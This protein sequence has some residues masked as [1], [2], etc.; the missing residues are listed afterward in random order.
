[1]SDVLSVNRSNQPRTGRLQGDAHRHVDDPT[2][3]AD[4]HQLAGMGGDDAVEGGG[5]TGVQ[6]GDRLAT[7]ID[8]PVGVLQR[9]VRGEAGDQVVVRH[10]VALLARVE[11]G[12]ALVD[13]DLGADHGSDELGRLDRP[14]DVAGI[15]HGAG[16]L[17]RAIE[18]L[19]EQL[20][21]RPTGV[22][23]PT[24]RAEVGD[25]PRRVAHGFAVADQ[26]EAGPGG[27]LFVDGHPVT[28]LA[29]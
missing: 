22:G 20:T 8:D 27:L 16:E 28:L 13:A 24:A 29:L 7:G 12:E 18:A 1:M 17:A 11:L 19:G 10:P 5:D 3:G 4:R 2:V 23:E 14:A 15:E 6:A 26:H 21:L 25:R 9:P